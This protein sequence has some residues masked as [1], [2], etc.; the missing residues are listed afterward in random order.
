MIVPE[1][2]NKRLKYRLTALVFIAVLTVILTV[3][4]YNRRS[5]DLSPNH[6]HTPQYASQNIPSVNVSSAES[7][8]SKNQESDHSPRKQQNTRLI[9]NTSIHLKTALIDTSQPKQKNYDII[10]RMFNQRKQVTTP[11]GTLP[12]LIQFCGPIQQIWKDDLTACGIILHDYVPDNTYL[13]EM[14][15]THALNIMDKPYIQWIEPYKNSYKI[16]PD[17]INA[18]DPALEDPIVITI[19]TLLPDDAE[20]LAEIFKHTITI[21]ATTGGKRWGFV[22]A[23]APVAIIPIIAEQGIVQWIEP[24]HAPT[25]LN[26]FAVRDYHM[27]VT[28]VWNLHDLTGSNQIIGHADSGLDIGNTNGIHADFAGRIKAAYGLGRP[29]DWSDPDGHG[30]HTGG[31]I[32]GDGTCSTG[33]F[34]GVAW[35]AQ[36]V[37]QSIQD[38]WGFLSGLP[39]DLNDLFLQA[40]NDGA[41]IHSDSW[42]SHAYGQYTTPSQQSDEFMWDHKDMLIVFSAGNDGH[43]GNYD[44]V[45]DPDSIGSPATAKNVLSVGATENDRAPGSGGYSSYRYGPSWLQDY[46]V[47]PIYSDY[48]SQSADGIHQGMAAFS[49]RGPTDDGRIKPDIVAPGTDI[50]SCYSQLP[51][52]DV[53]WGLHPN[54]KYTFSGGTSMSCPL[55]AGAAALVRQYLIEYK[56]ITNPSAALVKAT[57]VNGARSITPGQYGTSTTREIPATR[58]NTVEGF[59]QVNLEYSLFPEAPRSVAVWDITHGIQTGETNEYPISINS[60]DTLHLTLAYT[61]YPGTAGSGKQLVND[62]DIALIGPDGTTYYPNGFTSPDR[63]NNIE[64]ID[65]DQPL[66][67]TYIVRISAYNVPEGPQPYAFIANGNFGLSTIIEHTP[68]SNV[69]DTNNPYMVEATITSAAPINTNNVDLFWNTDGTTNSFSS[70]SFMHVT[71]NIYRAFIPAHPINTMI[72][73]YISVTNFNIQNQLPSNAPDTLF[74]FLVTTPVTLVINGIPS[75]LNTPI[76][77]YGTHT[78]ATGNLIEASV[79][80]TTSPSNGIRQICL[81]WLGS[82]SVPSSGSSNRVTFTITEDSIIDWTWATQYA[83]AQTS[84]IPNTINTTSWWRIYSK[85]ETISAPTDTIHNNTNYHFAYWTLDGSRQPDNDQIAANPARINFMTTNHNATAI[86]LPDNLDSDSDGIADWWEQYWFGTND[87]VYNIDTDNDGYTNIKEYQDRTNPHSSNDF[88]RPPSIT[89]TALSNPTTTPAPWPITAVITD[90]YRVASATLFWNHNTSGWHNSHMTFDPSSG[91]YTNVI[92]P[93]G[94]EGDTIQYRIEATDEAGMTTINGPY[95]I[96]VSYAITTITPSNFGTLFIPANM[97]TTLV[98]SVTNNGS[99][100]F[101]WNAQIEQIGLTDNIENGTNRWLHNGSVDLWHISTNRSWSGTH[102]WYCGDDATHEYKNSMN[103]SLITPKTFIDTNATLSFM[104]WANIEFSSGIHYWDGGIVE[105]STNNGVDFEQIFPIGGYPYLIVDNPAS[106]F[107]ANTP[108]LA[109]DGSGW[110]KVTFDLSNYR[111]QWIHIRFRFGSDGLT[112]DEGWYLDDISITQSTSNLLWLSTISTYGDVESNTHSNISFIA[113]THWTAPAETVYALI[114]MRHNDPL[115]DPDI[116]IPVIVHNNSRLINVTTTG[117]GF[118]NPSGSILV[119][120]GKTQAFEIASATYYDIGNIKTNGYDITLSSGLKGTNIIWGNVISNSTMSIA[121]SA[122]TT[123][124]NTPIWWL[125]QNQLTNLGYETESTL[126]QDGDTMAAWEEYIADTD[127]N[128]IASLFHITDMTETGNRSITFSSSTGR[129]YTI[130]T[131]TNL[132]APVWQI[133]AIV[134]GSNSV[135]T[136][137]DPSSSDTIFYRITVQQP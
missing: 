131:A 116:Y 16:D 89:H 37:H 97:A 95:Q 52:A 64:N 70:S 68:L 134:N 96:L 80:L 36:L 105:I 56:S 67:G 115:L 113:D 104:Q 54:S 49:S 119:E 59:G 102:A 26:D 13:A 74:S 127:P 43:D 11:R 47:N 20:S 126:D 7:E 61:D 98:V 81:G 40:Y 87:A 2:M 100:T 45:V 76:P 63:T 55:V 69:G 58:P 30:T 29:G 117:S 86:Y 44:G 1:N 79:E 118:V 9:D 42:G 21:L 123:S 57:L 77:D 14:D 24:Y 25:L 33:Q 35:Q 88:P 12:F 41:R 19:Q 82:G 6:T 83:L 101:S 103:A 32:L 65:L 53:G 90:N 121:F 31:S 128:D 22:R 50:I 107:A 17:L 129:L 71:N 110:E 133:N 111:N 38:Q 18:I 99:G 66:P 120:Y 94:V 125:E 93:P 84:S 27:N 114:H 75:L 46:P 5:P 92:P 124:N 34:R 112:V 73:Y 109:G 72:Y 122:I 135:T 132:L 3:I 51:G 106:P 10:T 137:T 136:I 62:I 91:L 39:S 8:S 85:V 15:E 4:R 23:E 130:R 28:N 48:I 78:Y 60:N 108:C